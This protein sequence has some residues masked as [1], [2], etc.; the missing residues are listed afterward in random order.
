[1]PESV[2]TRSEAPVGCSGSR[3]DG[4]LRIMRS[5]PAGSEANFG[6]DRTLAG[7][8]IAG[9]EAALEEFCDR[10]LPALQRFALHRLG[11]DPELA[12]DIVQA[13]VC[14]AIAKLDSYRGEAALMTWLCACCRNEIAGHY[15]RLRWQAPEVDIEDLEGRAPAWADEG[16]AG[17]V[18][19][20]LVRRETGTIVHMTLD[21]MP[22][23]YARA[24][25]WK[26]FQGLS[27]RRIA[28]R[29]EIGEKAAESLLT[30]SRRAF[31]R[32]YLELVEGLGQSHGQGLEDRPGRPFEL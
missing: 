29:L 20:D 10:Y 31:E 24:L 14:K 13:T 4:R 26:Y 23:R 3:P 15:R 18:E 2:P 19:D 25:E 28:A 17:D 27:V 32:Q 8:M 12:R 22:A 11:R 7:R 6:A 16:S 30:R 9:D 5:G 21:L 1:M